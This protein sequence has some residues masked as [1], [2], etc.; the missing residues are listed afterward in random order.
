MLSKLMSNPASF[1]GT[2]FC[3][4]KTMQSTMQS[5]DMDARR[6]H[7]MDWFYATIQRPLFH[8][9]VA[10]ERLTIL[11]NRA[12]YLFYQIE[13]NPT[14]TLEEIRA[15]MAFCPYP[16]TLLNPDEQSAERA[17]VMAKAAVTTKWGTL[18]LIRHNSLEEFVCNCCDGIKKSKTIARWEL[19]NG[20]EKIVCNGCYGS[21]LLARKG[22]RSLFAERIEA[23]L[24]AH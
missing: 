14:K 9:G 10:K 6:Q 13:D 24:H 21:I 2:V 8:D 23:M 19:P 15:A 20:T 18:Q 4:A 17:E 5:V 22:T 16:N 3:A 1:D 7:F 12:R 11:R